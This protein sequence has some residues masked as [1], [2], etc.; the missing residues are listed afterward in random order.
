M[1]LTRVFKTFTL[2]HSA[3]QQ[4]DREFQRRDGKW[5]LDT[6][7]LE[8][9]FPPKHLATSYSKWCGT[10]LWTEEILSLKQDFLQEYAQNDP[11]L[12]KNRL[13]SKMS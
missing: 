1:N 11:L 5:K 6:A 4:G 7:F 2:V 3:E 10:T 12:G 13:A 9:P 8:W